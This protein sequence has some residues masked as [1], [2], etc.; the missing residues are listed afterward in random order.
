MLR[1]ILGQ[2]LVLKQDSEID[3]EARGIIDIAPTP[4]VSNKLNCK[5]KSKK[6]KGECMVWW[7]ILS[8]RSIP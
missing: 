7:L 1:G 2:K 5:Y 6:E 8:K 4:I 3:L